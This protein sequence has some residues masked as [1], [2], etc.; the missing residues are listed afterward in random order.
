MGKIW[1]IGD[2]HLA[3]STPGK[4]MDFFGGAWMDYTRKIEENWKAVVGADDLVLVPGDISWALKLQDAVRDLEWLDK[5]P[6]TK[7]MIR[8]NHD[9]WWGS[10]SQVRAALPPSMHVLQNDIFKWNEFEIGGARLWDTPEYSYS[11]FVTLSYNPRAVEKNEDS[12]HAAVEAEKIFVRE[13]GRL[14]TSLKL[15]KGTK[16]LAMVHYPP[17]GPDLAPSRASALLEKYHVQTCLFGHIHQVPPN[18]IPMGTARGVTYHLTSADYLDFKP[19][20]ILTP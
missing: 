3:V 2:L 1:A 12:T 19:L 15:F 10:I 13:L 5:L 16:R 11:R 6:G 9:L 17:I 18:A 7:L 14:E 20:F 4:E 8:G